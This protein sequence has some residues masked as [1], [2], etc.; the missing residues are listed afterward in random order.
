MYISYVVKYCCF[1]YWLV[2]GSYFLVWTVSGKLY[3]VQQQ[4][5]CK[6][7]WYAK[8]Y[9]FQR[10]MLWLCASIKQSNLGIS[11]SIQ[12]LIIP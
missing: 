11:S 1:V 7:T 5:P 6:K 8:V 3:I 12:S 2:M 10:Y 4:N 9:I